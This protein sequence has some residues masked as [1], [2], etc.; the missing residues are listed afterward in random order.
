M[1]EARAVSL[2]KSNT[3]EV[4]NLPYRRP[5]DAV[6]SNFCKLEDGSYDIYVEVPDSALLA[7]KSAP[8]RQLKYRNDKR[9]KGLGRS[10]TIKVPRKN[11]GCTNYWMRRENGKRYL[12][13]ELSE[14]DLILCRRRPSLIDILWKFAAV[15][16]AVFS[17]TKKYLKLAFQIQRI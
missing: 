9:L 17:C 8:K 4:E 5:I 14:D 13:V 16:K 3:I 7:Q 6:V 11:I 15:V 12:Y 2:E 1:D 10:N